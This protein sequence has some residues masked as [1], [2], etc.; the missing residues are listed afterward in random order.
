[1]P[2]LQ[3]PFL[4]RVSASGEVEGD[5]WQN[6]S[7]FEQRKAHER[8]LAELEEASKPKE[9]QKPIQTRKVF[10]YSERTY[11]D[12]LERYGEGIMSMYSQGKSVD[13]IRN[14]TGMGAV[15]VKRIIKDMQKAERG[16]VE[17]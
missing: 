14:I 9:E 1:M 17:K 16:K 13:H 8:Y 11:K 10:K 5:Y 12:K 2:Q 6:L 4:V 3:E 15:T 7:D